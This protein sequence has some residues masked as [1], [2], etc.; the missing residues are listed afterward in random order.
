VAA[1]RRLR[2]RCDPRG[3]LAANRGPLLGSRGA[4]RT[5]TR[6]RRGG[7][8]F[9]PGPRGVSTPD[10]H[11][12]NRASRTALAARGPSMR[13]RTP[14]EAHRNTAAPS[15]RPVARQSDDASSPGLPGPTTRA[16]TADPSPAAPPGSAACHVRGLATSL[17]ASTTVPAGALRRRSVPRLHPSRR[18]P[19]SDGYPS[20]DPCPPALRRAVS[21]RPHEGVRAR[22]ATGLRARCELVLPPSK[23]TA[24]RCLPGLHPSRAFPPPVPAPR[25]CAESPLLRFRAVASPSACVSGFRVTEGSVGPSRGYRLSWGSLTLRPSR[26]RGDRNGKR[27]HGFTSRLRPLEAVR[28]DPSLLVA[29]RRGLSPPPGPA[30]LR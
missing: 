26:R 30:V 15:R 8:G 25:G 1:L 23:G 13:F 7:H 4:P 17:A 14:S 2:P 6:S 12:R 19:R 27:A 18:S 21:P 11:P 9:P 24:R 28:T 10:G 22:W 5:R 20:R 29:T 3:R 16:E